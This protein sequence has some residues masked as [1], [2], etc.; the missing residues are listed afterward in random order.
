MNKRKVNCKKQNM[1]LLKN[2]KERRVEAGREV[3]NQTKK[4]P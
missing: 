3:Q 4:I 1:K 2:K